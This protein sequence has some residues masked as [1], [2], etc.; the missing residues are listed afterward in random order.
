MNLFIQMTLL[1]L[2]RCSLVFLSSFI[3][4]DPHFFVATYHHQ[5]VE[6]L[7]CQEAQ[8]TAVHS[9]VQVDT[10]TWESIG[11]GDILYDSVH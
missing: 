8:A 7:R 10:S 4:V 3:S 2:L 11:M 9:M 6:E 1:L 5:L